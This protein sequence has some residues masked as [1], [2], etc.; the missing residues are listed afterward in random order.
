MSSN[1]HVVAATWS[2]ADFTDLDALNEPVLVD[3]FEGTKPPVLI[4]PRGYEQFV[5]LGDM[6]NPLIAE[7]VAVHQA[8]QREIQRAPDAAW[9]DR[10]VEIRAVNDKILAAILVAPK[11]CPRERLQHGRPPAGQLWWGSFNDTQRRLLV[12]FWHSGIEALKSVRAAAG[13]DE[14]AIRGGDG[15]PPTA[16]PDPD[17]ASPAV[18]AV[19]AGRSGTPLA[20]RAGDGREDSG[21]LSNT[22]PRSPDWGDRGRPVALNDRRDT[23]GG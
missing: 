22:S 6:G 14:P 19:D 8:E 3:I 16:Q 9:V 5:F 4:D 10:A 1:G 20:E 13:P 12:D 7:A 23:V 17:S 11:Y 15:L 18:G 2:A 21:S